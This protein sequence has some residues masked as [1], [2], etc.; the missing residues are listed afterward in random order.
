MGVRT[1]F[2]L[3]AQLPYLSE[4]DGL[5]VSNAQQQASID[6]NEQGTVLVSVTNMH[7]IALSVQPEVPDVVFNV[8]R[9]FIVAIADR[10]RYIPYCIAKITNPVA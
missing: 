9:P 5:Q 1:L 8:N 10:T 3:N 2:S 4:S 6:V 7:V